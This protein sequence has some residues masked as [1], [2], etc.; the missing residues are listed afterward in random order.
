MMERAFHVA[1]S[2][3]ADLDNAAALAADA[4]AD[5]QPFVY[6][7][8]SNV[9]RAERRRCLQPFFRATFG[10]RQKHCCCYSAFEDHEV[11]NGA[12]RLL[13]CFFMLVASELQEPSFCDI[14][15]S[16]YVRALAGIG[17]YRAWRMIKFSSWASEI[18]A[19][20]L[21]QGR[22]MRL[23]GMATLPARQSHGLGSRALQHALSVADSQ[24]IEVFLATQDRRSVRFYERA[25]F[26]L[27][28]EATYEQGGF[29]T[30]F[31]RRPPAS[32][33]ESTL[34]ATTATHSTAETG[35]SGAAVGENNGTLL[36][37]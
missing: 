30:W 20:L 35:T 8:G 4:F 36:A 23:E 16:G 15:R 22:G 32:P 24:G 25:G 26:V 3:Q 10:V 27:A 12:C 11:G 37:V 5:S 31:M 28:R 18:E 33:T 6:V 13:V 9:D 14:W 7:F 19:E 21:F 17:L 2:V 29:S 34:C 1:E